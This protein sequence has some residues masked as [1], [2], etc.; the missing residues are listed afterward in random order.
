VLA[1][2]RDV[3]VLYETLRNDIADE[4]VKMPATGKSGGVSTNPA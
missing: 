4:G 1:G 2:T 3:S